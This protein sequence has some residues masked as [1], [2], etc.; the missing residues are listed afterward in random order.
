MVDARKGIRFVKK[1]SVPILVVRIHNG[2]EEVQ[3]F[4]KMDNTPMMMNLSYKIDL[5]FIYVV[6]TRLQHILF[7]I[8]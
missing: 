3:L 4:R 1:K 7:F 2:D 5:I 6:C 8:F